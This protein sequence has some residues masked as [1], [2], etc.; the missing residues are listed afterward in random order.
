ME[1]L[2]LVPI[3]AITEVRLGKTTERLR[4]YAQPFE[5]ESVFSIIYANGSHDNESLDLVASNAD[6]ANIW[7]TGLSCLIAGCG[8][9]TTS[10]GRERTDDIHLF[11]RSKMIFICLVDLEYRQQMRDRWLHD[12]FAAGS[13]SSISESELSNHQDCQFLTGKSSIDE[14]EAIRLLSDHGISEETAKIR[15]QVNECHSNR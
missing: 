12:A 13:P 6:E 11:S 9:P 3:D 15:L 8:N 1:C 7:V 5:N 14:E 2:D 4:E 10:A